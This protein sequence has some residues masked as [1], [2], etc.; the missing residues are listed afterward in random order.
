MLPTSEEVSRPQT[1]LLL[2]KKLIKSGGKKKKKGGRVFG[3]LRVGAEVERGCRGCPVVGGWVSPPL[4]PCILG[5][6]G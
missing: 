5:G 2:Q 6:G 4:Q 3:W 1:E